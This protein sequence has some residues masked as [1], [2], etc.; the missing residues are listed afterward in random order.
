MAN[1]GPINCKIIDCMEYLIDKVSGVSG[2]GG[3]P[4]GNGGGLPG[5][6]P[7]KVVIQIHHHQAS[8][9]PK[10]PRKIER[11]CLV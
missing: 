11:I 4:S 7:I 3:I 8:I 10:L 6:P 2:G 5:G 1:G 9:L